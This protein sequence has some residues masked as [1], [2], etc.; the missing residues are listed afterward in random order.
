MAVRESGPFFDGQW[1]Q[2]MADVAEQAQAAIGEQGVMLVRQHLD[3]VLRHPTGAYRSRVDAT[4]RTA[5]TTVN[6]GGVVYGPWLE[7]TGSRNRSSRFK[8]YATFR[9]VTDQ[10]QQDALRITTDLVAH[11]VRRLS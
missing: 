9:R 2:V 11:A 3:G 8:G 4:N 1:E 6:D 10:L 5:D 7:G